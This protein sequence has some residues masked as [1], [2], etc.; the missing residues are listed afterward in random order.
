MISVE[1][2]LERMLELF[3]PLRMAKVNIIL[4]TLVRESSTTSL[5]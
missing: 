2:T 4:D 5:L 1:N 3:F